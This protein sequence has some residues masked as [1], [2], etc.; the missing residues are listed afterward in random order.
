MMAPSSDLFAN[1]DYS[2]WS[3]IFEPCSETLVEAAS[4]TEGSHVLDVAAGNGNTS[5]AAARR[6][7]IVTALD[8]SPAQIAR[9]STRARTE[10]RPV[11]WVEG[12]ATNLPF[13]GGTFDRT[14]NSFGD[15]IVVEEMFRVVRPGGVVGIAGWTGEDFDSDIEQLEAS[16]RDGAEEGQ[17]SHLWGRKDTVH[18]MLEPSAS[19]V[20][21]RRHVLPVRFESV[22]AFSDELFRKDPYMHALR[23]ELPSDRWWRYTREV[24]RIVARWNKARDGSLLLEMPYLVTVARKR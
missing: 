17:E 23:K 6:G 8:F 10:R 7:A 19:S 15:V 24:P 12:D 1:G 13:A 2:F 9:G 4:I 18:R 21:V 14:F 5:L 16:L 22:D 11:A 3:R 20:D